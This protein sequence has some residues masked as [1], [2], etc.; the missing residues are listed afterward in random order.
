MLFVHLQ[1]RV[2]Y[3]HTQN[4][5]TITFYASDN[6]SG[7]AKSIDYQIYVPALIIIV[8]GHLKEKIQAHK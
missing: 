6:K 5:K 7:A 1:Q 8:R 4:S 2:A 3:L